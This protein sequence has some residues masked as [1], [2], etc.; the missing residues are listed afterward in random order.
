M[1]TSSIMYKKVLNNEGDFIAL[2]IWQSGQHLTI[3]F[4]DGTFSSTEH[5][6]YWDT[7]KKTVDK[8]QEKVKAE[9]KVET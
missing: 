8:L 7:I 2:E 9:T 4:K 6:D 3:Q 5:S 1:R